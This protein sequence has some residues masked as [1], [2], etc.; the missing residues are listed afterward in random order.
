MVRYVALTCLMAC[1]R[2]SFAPPIDAHPCPR[3]AYDLGP[4]PSQPFGAPVLIAELNSPD[5]DD[6]PTLTAD[7]LEIVFESTRGGSSRLW[8]SVRATTAASWPAPTPITE[9]DGWL[10]NTPELSRDG[11]RLRFSTNGDVF[12]TTRFDRAS[13]WEAPVIAADITTADFESGAVE[14]LGGTAIAFGSGRSGGNTM[15]DLWEIVQDP[16]DCTFTAPRVLPGLA[17]PVGKAN[18]WM[19][20]DGLAV[21][22]PGVGATGATDLVVATRPDLDSPFAVPVEQTTL[23]STNVDDDPWMNDEMTSIYFISGRT[24]ETAIYHAQR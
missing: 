19:R 24:F 14:F 23:N 8:H 5:G 3:P 7:E 15:G 11:L 6:D 1:G 9:L 13:A 17:S 2:L 22:F 4:P 12:L 21:A 16:S 10:A 20:D 18:P